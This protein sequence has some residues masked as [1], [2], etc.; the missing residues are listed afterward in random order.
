MLRINKYFQAEKNVLIFNKLPPIQYKVGVP[1]DPEIPEIAFFGR[2]NAGKSSLINEVCSRRQKIQVVSKTPGR[3]QLIYFIM[4]NRKFTLVD[5][6]GYGFAAISK[7]QS[8]KFQKLSMEYIKDAPNRP[9]K[10]VAI[11]IDSRR[12]IA[13]IDISV[14]DLCEEIGA[15]YSII[16]TKIDKLSSNA[17]I[18]SISGIEK[19]IRGRKYCYPE[20]IRTSSKDRIDCNRTNTAKKCRLIHFNGQP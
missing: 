1:A 4:F 3:T 14:M 5:L 16:M 17:L 10:N 13:E 12:G 20:V 9:L 6:P 15:P 7:A 11:L 8:E 2:S 18:T 19:F